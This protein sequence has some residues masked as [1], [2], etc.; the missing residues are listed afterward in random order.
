[1]SDD[2]KK[3]PYIVF[4]AER[5]RGRKLVR[6]LSFLL[7]LVFL[8]GLISNV[9]WKIAYDKATAHEK[10]DSAACDSVGLFIARKKR[11]K[12]CGK[13]LMNTISH[14]VSG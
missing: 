10:E 4:E 7:A 11:F 1:M 8:A 6:L 9:F 2:V 3:V 14:V 5:I 12:I 13:T